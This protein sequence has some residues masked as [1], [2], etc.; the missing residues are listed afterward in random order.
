MLRCG[1]ICLFG[2]VFERAQGIEDGGG[3]F[4]DDAVFDDAV[5]AREI[6]DASVRRRARWLAMPVGEESSACAN[7]VM[8]RSPSSSRKRMAMRSGLAISLRMVERR[9]ISI[10]LF[11]LSVI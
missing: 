10:L 8:L 6:D 2:W 5:V 11:L 1:I 4:G 9:L 3:F 7:S